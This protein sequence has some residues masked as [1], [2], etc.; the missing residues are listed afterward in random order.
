M[1]RSECIHSQSSSNRTG[2]SFVNGLY[3]CFA[4]SF[5]LDPTKMSADRSGRAEMGEC[6]S[7]SV[8]PLA[9]IISKYHNW[10]NF[11]VLFQWSSPVILTLSWLK[12]FPGR[13][14]STRE[15]VSSA[16]CNSSRLTTD[17]FRLPDT[18][19]LLSSDR[20]SGCVPCFSSSRYRIVHSY[21]SDSSQYVCTSPSVLLCLYLFLACMCVRPI[22]SRL[23]NH[24]FLTTT[25][26]IYD[27]LF[28][29]R[30][31]PLGECRVYKK[32]DKGCTRTLNISFLDRSS[33]RNPRGNSRISP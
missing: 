12:I 17:G 22:R 28:S 7:T 25:A 24:S 5:R 8:T 15:G 19:C 18:N 31:K 14:G 23:S 16:N 9:E 13:C 3:M 29:S 10:L 4:F 32:S 1:G 6:P 21:K 27:F 33:S 30:V 20:W 2:F 26:F 11:V